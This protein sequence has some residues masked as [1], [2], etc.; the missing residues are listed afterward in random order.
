MYIFVLIRLLVEIYSADINKF[1][2]I[3]YVSSKH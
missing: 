3:S 2:H 1:I